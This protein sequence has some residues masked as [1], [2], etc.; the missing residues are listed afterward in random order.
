MQLTHLIGKR[1]LTGAWIVE[2]PPV[3]PAVAER[4][5]A[6]PRMTGTVRVQI[7]PQILVPDVS[8][9]SEVR[10]MA[11][12]LIDEAR[13]K[14]SVRV[15]M[16]RG[17]VLPGARV[18]GGHNVQTFEAGRVYEVG[19]LAALRLLNS[20]PLRYIFE[21]VGDDGDASLVSTIKNNSDVQL[22][23]LQEQ[24]RALTEQL[25]AMS[26]RAQ[27]AAPTKRKLKDAL[28]DADGQE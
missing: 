22:R 3:T 9:S 5:D 21:E 14:G 8:V 15:I 1:A 18:H 27:V 4:L 20:D 7:R 28:G 12:R 23:D 24:V 2:P 25:M 13:A 16:D 10:T 19:A 6:L 11:G 26:A 17:K